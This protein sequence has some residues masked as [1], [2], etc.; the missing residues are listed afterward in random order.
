M[1]IVQI[2]PFLEDSTL[3]GASQAQ[4]F[5]LVAFVS[6]GLLGFFAPEIKRNW[7]ILWSKVDWYPKI[8]RNSL[9]LFDYFNS[10]VYNQAPET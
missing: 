5:A 10:K 6:T 3:S 9:M 4:S 1:K 8:K 2:G 7:L